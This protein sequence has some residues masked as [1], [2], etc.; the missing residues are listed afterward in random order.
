MSTYQMEQHPQ[1]L[2]QELNEARKIQMGMLPQSVP[3]ISG[4]QIAAYSMPATAVGGDFYDFI[5]LGDGRLGVVIGDAVGHGFPAALLM[6]MT[7]TDFRSLA[8]RH[9]SPAEVLNSVNSRLVQSMRTK[10]SVTSIY[11]VLDLTVKRLMCAMAGMQ[12]WLIKARP[13]EC[14]P[15]EPYGDRFPLGISQKSQ[16]QSCDVQM[17]AGDALVLYTDGV[18]EATNEDDEIYSFERLEKVLVNKSGADA[19]ELLDAVM[20]DVRQFTGNRPLE[21]DITLVVLKATESIAVAPIVPTAMLITGEQK[22]VTMLFAIGDNELPADV[23]KRVNTLLREHDGMMDVMSDDTI[24]ALFGVPTLH[25]DDAER[26]VTAAQAIQGLDM[27]ITFRIGI[28][29]GT[30]V[31]RSDANIDYHNMGE[32]M[33]FALH[34][35]NSAEPDQ[36]LMSERAHQLTRGAFQFSAVTQVQPYDDE[37]IS[38]YPVIAS[39]EQPHHARGIQGLYSPMIGREREM[40]RMTTCID[41]LLNGRGQIVSITGDA[42]IGKTRLVSELRQYAG[43]RVQWLEGR[44]IS[45]GQAMNYGPFRGIISSYL[46]ML[47]T[48]TEEEMKAKLQAKINALLPSSSRWIPIHVGSMFFPQYEAE[49]RTASG[50][51]YAKQYTYPIMRNLFHKVAEKKPLVLVFEDLHWADPTSLALLEFLMESVDEAPILYIWVYRPYRDSEAWRLRQRAD[52]DFAYCYI[53]IDLPPLRSDQTDTIV[54]ELLRIP[55]IPEPIRSLVQDKA[56]GN[57][58]YVEEIIRSFIDGEVVI[59]DAEYWRAT[60][61]SAEIVPSDTLQGVI[62]SRVDRLDPEAKETLQVASVIG[63]SFP[64]SLLEQVSGSE[65][66]SGLLR[67][68]EGAEMLLRQRA[69]NEWEYHFRHPLIHDVVYHSLLPKDRSALHDKTGKAIES[70]HSERLDDYIDLLAHHYGHSDNIEKALHYLILAGD[71]AFELAS[72]WESLD[73]YGMAM[74]KAEGLTDEQRRK[75]TIVDLV[76]KRSTAR[77]MLGALKPDVEEH[78]KYLGLVEELADKDRGLSLYRWL[79]AHYF[80][81]FEEFGKFKEYCEKRASLGGDVIILDEKIFGKGYERLR[82]WGFLAKGQYESAIIV[83][84]Q[85]AE[86]AKMEKDIAYTKTLIPLMPVIASICNFL[87]IMAKA[88]A[89]MG[90]WNESL[91]ACQA[92]LDAAVEYSESTYIMTGHGGLGNTY[93]AMGEWDKAIAECETFLDMSPTGISI[94]LVAIPLGDAYCKAGQIDKGIALLERWKTYV[95]R[96]GRGAYD[97]CEYCLPLAEGYLMRGDISKAR[98]NTDEALQIAQEHGYALHEAKAYRILGEIA[99]TDLPSAEE[100]FSRSLE[101]LKRI[102]A[103]NEEGKTELSWGRACKQ[104]RNLSKAREHLTSA[105]EIFEELGT[106]RYLEWTRETIADLERN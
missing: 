9:V 67:K 26:A 35:A 52:K 68:L 91:R 18:L 83:A 50:D 10:K 101:V 36:V 88:Y 46:G 4:F 61:E 102:K 75:Q 33:R 27:P 8:P 45:Y 24:V 84:G 20:T 57:P 41:D 2:T 90:H 14:I 94:G 34:L 40:E 5:P 28:D 89:A 13:R 93:V 47:P 29:T 70:M 23:V 76:I 51:D 32:T 58:L 66:L 6:T 1:D 105:V 97:E 71:K 95:K 37:T 55:D 30:A 96:V 100:Y 74:G 12:P 99:P 81:M 98:A 79:I 82:A 64:L 106:T 60:A 53:E 104:N 48:D 7:L 63:V 49:L 22:S 19:Q 25:E 87:W 43:D 85:I 16:Y 69:G 62:L 54:S 11:A 17:E 44:C 39:A 3:E 77:H 56:S 72:Y 80:L 65:A 21:D 92:I 78:E 15:I 38:A 86:A 59:R 103:R 73:Y 42:G 31:V